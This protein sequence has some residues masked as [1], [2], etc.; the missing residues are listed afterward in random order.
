[1]RFQAAHAPRVGGPHFFRPACPAACWE[2][3]ARRRIEEKISY[4]NGEFFR[5][6]TRR[7]SRQIPNAST[8]RG[9]P[10]AAR[11]LQ[12]AL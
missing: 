10:T 11:R 4:P 9:T 5:C 3:A 1:M 6:R 7:K 2:E 12:E 8:T